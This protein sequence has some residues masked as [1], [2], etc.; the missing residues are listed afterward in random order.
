LPVAELSRLC[1]RA[2]TNEDFE[3]PEVVPPESKATPKKPQKP[4]KPSDP[5]KPHE[6]E[7]EPEPKFLSSTVPDSDF[8]QPSPEVTALGN[9]IGFATMIGTVVLVCVVF[10]LWMR[11][12]QR[13]KKLVEAQTVDI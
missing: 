6:R 12:R 8:V 13:R 3:A 4:P 1:T 11:H 7:P 5:T 2:D 9:A 10:V